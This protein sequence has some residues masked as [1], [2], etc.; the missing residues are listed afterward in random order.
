MAPRMVYGAFARCL[1]CHELA[2][3]L[4]LPDIRAG[5]IAIVK[6]SEASELGRRR[7]TPLQVLRELGAFVEAA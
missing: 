6:A 7:L 4:I 1:G 2:F 5:W 3:L